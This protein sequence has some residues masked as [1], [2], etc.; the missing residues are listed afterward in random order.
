MQFWLHS[1]W[2]GNIMDELAWKKKKWW[3]LCK[4]CELPLTPSPKNQ[5]LNESVEKCCRP[6]ICRIMLY[7]IS[8]N[9]VLIVINEVQEFEE[10]LGMFIILT[11][12]AWSAMFC[13]LWG[14]SILIW[15]FLDLKVAVKTE[16]WR[17]A[18]LVFTSEYSISF[19]QTPQWSLLEP[20]PSSFILSSRL[21]TKY[22][23][24]FHVC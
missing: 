19:P 2:A 15:M 14:D 8:T 10:A 20:C 24:I 17:L 6:H 16:L 9:L 23:I 3:L 1:F 13:I 18:S 12:T 11:S 22:W 21:C 5:S 7:F 4:Y